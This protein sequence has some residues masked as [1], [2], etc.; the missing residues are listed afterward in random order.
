LAAWRTGAHLRDHFRDH[1]RELGCS[2]PEEYDASAQA[3]LD[4][5]TY[6]EYFDDTAQETRT[7][8][9]DRFTERLTILDIDDQIV[10]HFRCPDWY[11]GGLP[12]SSYDPPR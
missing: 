9:Y 6:F 10:S 7:G 4:H 1:G 8:C 11:V 3:T 2:T 12:D 5:G